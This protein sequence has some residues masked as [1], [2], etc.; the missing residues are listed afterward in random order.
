MKTRLIPC[1]LG[2][3]GLTVFGE[4]I[5]ADTNAWRVLVY[6][7]T[8]GY[9][10]DSITNGVQAIRELGAK[11]GFAVE[12]TE[13]SNTLTA[14]N[15]ARFRAVVFLS[16]TGDVLSAEQE[17]ALSGYVENGGGLASIHGAIFG[18][19][20][21]ED[22]WEWYHE[23]CGCA[24]TNHSAIVPATV[25]IEEPRQPSTLGLPARWQRADEWY[26]FTG[27][28]R[29]KSRVLATVDE[30]T[31]AGGKMG[32][33]HPIAWCRK[34]GKGY[35]WYTAMGHTPECFQEPLL[36]QHILGGIETVAG[37]KQ[38]DFTPNSR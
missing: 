38:A 30:S 31:Y 7:K 11:N 12:A 36:L 19:S 10:H 29:G 13:D 20:A 26:N 28:P 3:V 23:V 25:V 22:H 17:Q 37:K 4:T 35:F 14:T 33:D 27:S 8:L 16:V 18:P 24:F 21:C 6:S 5:Q 15:L 34:S 2:L 1:L 32:A 9:R